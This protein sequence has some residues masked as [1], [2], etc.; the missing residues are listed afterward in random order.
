MKTLIISCKTL[1]NELNRA[2]AEC[3][4]A[5]EVK[6]VESGLH[7]VP[8]LLTEALQELL[9]ASP[10]YERILIAMGYC[11]NALAGL[12]TNEATMIIP[13]VDDCITFMLGSFARRT[14]LAG[15]HGVYFMTE[16][17]LRGERTIWHEYLYTIDKYGEKTGE[18]IFKM[19]LSNYTTLAMLDTGCFDLSSIEDEVKDIAKTL[20]LD[21]VVVPATVDYLKNLLTGPWGDDLF[22]TIP[23]HSE[24]ISTQLTMP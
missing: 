10:G 21:Y 18:D 9:D 4:C 22:L 14:E 2:M 6:W 7:N 8:K 16:G 15:G 1:E 19:M 24:I 17:W 5:Y 3:D 11:G 12:K 23:P 20:K 13:R